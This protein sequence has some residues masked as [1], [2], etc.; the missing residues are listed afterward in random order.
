MPSATMGSAKRDKRIKRPAYDDCRAVE[1][2]GLVESLVFFEGI[3]W[4]IRLTTCLEVCETGSEHVHIDRIR[5]I[6]VE[7]IGVSESDFFLCVAFI[8]AILRHDD[9]RRGRSERLDNLP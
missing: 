6:E 2:L 9:D 4:H 3:D 8:E 5:M 7:M 1:I